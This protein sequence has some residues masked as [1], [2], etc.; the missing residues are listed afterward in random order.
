MSDIAFEVRSASKFFPGVKALQDVSLEMPSG[1]I[2]A[3]LGENGAGKS[4]L[5]KLITG[6]YRP[7]RGELFAGSKPV[8]FTRP[9]DAIQ[10]GVG[11]V[12]QERNL[13]PRFS[14]GENMALGQM[15][16]KP[17]KPI[18]YPNIY[19]QAET[20]LRTLGLNID[21]KVAVSR[22]SVAQMQM[23][24]IA[25]A[26]S[27]QSRV[28]LLDEPTAS[29][30]P[31]ES[32]ALFAVLRKL[33]ADGVS[34]LFVS[35]KLEEVQEIC[36]TVSVLRDGRNAGSNVPMR[37]MSRRDL[38]KLMIGRDA[39]NVAARAGSSGPKTLALE[40]KDLATPEGH[41]RIN[42]KVHKG[43]IVGLYGLVGAGRT[44]LAKAIM[45]VTQVSGGQILRNGTPVTIQNPTDALHKQGIGYVS[46]NRK[47]E[48]L[49]IDHSVLEN[50]GITVWR[51]S[52]SKLGLLTRKNIARRTVPFLKRLA[53]KTPSLQETVGNLSGGN[54]QKIAISKWLAAG[55][56]VL[57]VD[58]PTVGID[59][60]SKAY[61][62]GLLKDL[63]DNG[64]AVLLITSDLPEMISL[65]E[66][67]MVMDDFQ[68]M[69]EVINDNDYRGMS[70]AVMD[71]IHVPASS[72]PAHSTEELAHEI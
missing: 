51:K 11:V 50:A 46:E 68:I 33:S 49:I 13:I 67:I 16:L 18:D 42:L 39:D 59:V 4:T 54:Q 45:G 56:E 47:D 64:T 30:T 43:E 10:A 44:E 38:I 65:A 2:H 1:S 6:V 9:Q 34:I 19:A 25:K 23:V 31:H 32:Q 37:D 66:R 3:L 57:L 26:L 52:A 36:D 40:L 20:W 71:L 12:H 62:H 58:E 8:R 55:V 69:G 7:D 60:G 72:N 27:Q 15:S 5:I 24:E 41:K 70:E 28:L 17:L 14:V 63:A 21:P 48:G 35:H 29:L 53:V 61:L 22:L